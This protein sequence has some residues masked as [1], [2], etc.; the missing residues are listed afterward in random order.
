VDGDEGRGATATAHSRR[1]QLGGLGRRSRSSG[2]KAYA[3]ILYLYYIH[4][5]Y[6]AIKDS[7][8]YRSVGWQF[9]LLHLQFIEIK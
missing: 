8:L 5:L 9:E 3:F 6:I 4:V 7:L 1:P 2:T